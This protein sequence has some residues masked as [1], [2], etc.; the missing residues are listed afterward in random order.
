MD[1]SKLTTGQKIAI[2]AGAVLLINLFLPWYGVLSISINAF[3]AGFLAWFGSFLA[4]AGAVLLALKVFAGNAVNAGNLRTE[5]IALVLGAMGTIF[6]ILRWLTESDLTKFGLFLGIIAA[7]AVTYGAFMS[8]K[9]EGLEM[10]SADD[11]KSIA[12]GDDEGGGG[13]DA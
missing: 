11:F 7:A 2:G 1:L 5:Q 12:G 4:I 3:D 9:D 10:P 13:E 8:M 6:I